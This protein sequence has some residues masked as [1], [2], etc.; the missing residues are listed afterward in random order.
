MCIV[1]TRG[2]GYIYDLTSIYEASKQIT[3]SVTTT[4]DSNYV[5]CET[6]SIT[7]NNDK[8]NI[9]INS[10]NVYTTDYA[11]NMNGVRPVSGRV[12]YTELE[13]VKN[14]LK[15][16][17]ASSG[18]KHVDS[19]KVMKFTSIYDSEIAFSNG[20]GIMTSSCTIEPDENYRLFINIEN[21]NGSF[22]LFDEILTAFPFEEDGTELGY[23][24]ANEKVTLISIHDEYVEALGG[25]YGLVQFTDEY[26]DTTE[27]LNVSVQRP[28]QIIEQLEEDIESIKS[29]SGNVDLTGIATEE[30][31]DNAALA[32]KNDLLNGAGTAYD[33]LKELG[34]LIDTNKT[35]IEAL[36]N[37]STNINNVVFWVNMVSNQPDKSYQ[38]I[39]DAH[40]DGK[41][42]LLKVNSIIYNLRSVAD[43]HVNFCIVNILNYTNSA[44]AN[45]HTYRITKDGTVYSSGS[46]IRLDKDALNK[47]SDNAVSN[48]LVTTKFEEL[49]ESLNQKSAVQIITWESD[50]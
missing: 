43:T 4:N 10:N 26:A 36:E 45:L 32:V 23:A 35:A 25:A 27:T 33:T 14:E 17:I 24:L 31:A 22:V 39:V 7:Y 42:V 2:A 1:A 19:S 3:F 48:K 15:T 11:L 8:A 9:K 29:V 5:N 37:I 20:Q 50:D 41:I 47:D 34:E 44:Y 46:E 16:L 30:Y 40:N 13:N 18:N 49:E 21:E 12:I 28:I 38:E 6:I